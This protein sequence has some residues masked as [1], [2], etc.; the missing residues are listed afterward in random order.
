MILLFSGGV[1]SYVAYHFLKKPQTV[2]FD[3][4]TP[5][6]QKEIRVVK[7]LIPKTIIEKVMDFSTRQEG[8]K[9]FIPYRN[10][11]LA[12]LANKYSDNIVIA[13]LKDD[14]VND[15]NETVFRQLSYLMTDMNNRHIWVNSPFWG[16]TKEDVVRWF[17]DNGGTKEKLLKTISCYSSEDTIYCGKCPACFRKFIAFRANGIYALQFINEDLMKDYLKKAEEGTHYIAERNK[18][19]IKVLKEYGL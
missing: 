9:A 11:H 13:G 18:T 14:K 3:L 2:Y 17:L 7:D 8:D 1:D 10:I 4:N 5:Y 12:M 16:L 15:K 19:I 6:S